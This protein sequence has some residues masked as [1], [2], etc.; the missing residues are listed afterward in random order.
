MLLIGSLIGLVLAAFVMESGHSGHEDISDDDALAPDPEDDN[1]PPV[2]PGPDG[3]PAAPRQIVGGD[4]GDTLMGSAGD[5]VIR[6]GAGA[7]DLRGG[8]GNDTIHGGGGDDWI[9]G[10]AA[11]GEGGNDVIFGGDGND[12]LNGQGGNDLIHGEEGDDTIFGGEGND[13][14]F[15][16][17]GNDWLSGNDGDDVL[18]STEGSDDLDGGRGNDV[19]IGHDGPETVWMNGGEGDDTLMPGANDF[20]SGN[21]GADTF[22]LRQ[23]P[24]GF[25][26]IADYDSAEDRIELHLSERVAR[27]AQLGLRED[28]DGTWLLEVNGQPVGRL[29]QHG[30]LRLEDIRIVPVR[31]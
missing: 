22:V 29:L 24:K 2:M 10:D 7:D 30:G 16:G 13:T 27:S 4:G 25:P 28:L 5:D 21:A 31:D 11:Y 9:Q 15:G 20:A 26:T 6:G 3:N 18:V 14:L 12:H 8:L 23:P 17:P 19:L 1:L